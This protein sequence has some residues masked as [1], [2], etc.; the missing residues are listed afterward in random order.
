MKNWDE[1]AAPW[2][3]AEARMEAAHAPVLEAM[4]ARADLRTG[5]RVL[6]IGIGSGLSTARAV[7]AVG[8][9]GLVTGV[10]VAPPFVAR[11]AERVPSDVTLLAADAE[12]HDFGGAGFERAISI[13]GTMFFDET[14]GAFANI[15]RAMAPGGRFTFAAWAPPASNPWLSIGGQAVTAILGPPDPRPD[16]NAPGPFRFALPDTALDALAASEWQAEVETLDLTLTPTG[17]PDEITATQMELGI[18]ARRIAEEDA[19]AEDT[20]AIFDTI[21]SRFRQMQNKAGA[22]LVPARVHIFTATA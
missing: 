15:R 8:Q 13:F 19:D 12:T 17:T 22:V 20:E 10:D 18:A 4:L 3:R 9:G 2:L 21:A 1:L 16:P 11:T 6:D 14:V 5:L 7:D